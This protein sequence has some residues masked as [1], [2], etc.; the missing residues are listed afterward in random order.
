[1][2]TLKSGELAISQDNEE[3]DEDDSSVGSTHG[4]HNLVG[5]EQEDKHKDEDNNESAH[6]RLLVELVRRL[7]GMEQSV[8]ALER[9][10]EYICD[11]V[12]NK[13]GI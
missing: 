5:D 11:T 8:G 12:S 4:I 13:S 1:M 2:Q 7:Q 3:E 9:R 10:W 6:T